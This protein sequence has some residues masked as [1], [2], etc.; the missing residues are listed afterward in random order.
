MILMAKPQQQEKR[1]QRRNKPT[2]VYGR[3]LKWV[4][5]RYGLT[6]EELAGI[7]E[8]SQSSVH[9]WLTGTYE[10]SWKAN[11]KMADTLKF[12][13]QLRELHAKVFAY[14]QG[15]AAPAEDPPNMPYS[16]AAL[17]ISGEDQER[18]DSVQRDW[19]ERNRGDNGGASH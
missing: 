13:K 12:D 15:V 14:G 9:N 6:Q 2:T 4:M 16:L 18:I 8:Y 10:A 1:R 7:M 11:T 17:V 3:F 19:E 5:F